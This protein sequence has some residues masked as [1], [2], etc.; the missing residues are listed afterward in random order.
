MSEHFYILGSI[1]ALNVWISCIP[2][3]YIDWL[4]QDNWMD[5]ACLLRRTGLHPTPMDNQ[6]VTCTHFAEPN[7]IRTC[8]YL[9]YV[10]ACAYVCDLPWAYDQELD[11]NNYSVRESLCVS[12]LNEFVGAVEH[13]AQHCTWLWPTGRHREAPF[14]A[15]KAQGGT[16]WGLRGTRKHYLRLGE[17]P[18]DAWE[19]PW[20]TFSLRA[21][22]GT[23]RYQLSRGWSCYHLS[24][25]GLK[26]IE[27]VALFY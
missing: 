6:S 24:P 14:E 18:F 10:R 11:T 17:A 16:I 15:W 3:Q 23:R 25:G 13:H 27:S 1:F 7:Q 12:I 22:G 21:L 20:G 4:S 9:W 26:G 8:M 5:W 2:V 19:A